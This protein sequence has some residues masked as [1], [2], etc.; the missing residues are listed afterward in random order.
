LKV[1]F[2]CEKKEEEKRNDGRNAGW[3]GERWALKIIFPRAIEET[4]VREERKSNVVKGKGKGESEEA[5]L[6]RI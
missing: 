1:K 5:E 3:I 2:L 6:E 4:Q